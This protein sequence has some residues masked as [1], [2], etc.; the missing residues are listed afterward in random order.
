MNREGREKKRKDEEKD[1]RL[2]MGN[3]ERK[4]RDWIERR[5]KKKYRK[6][7]QTKEKMGSNEKR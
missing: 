7:E 2:K 5:M 4:Q 6:L 1:L 3:E